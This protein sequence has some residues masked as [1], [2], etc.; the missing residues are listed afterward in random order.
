MVQEAVRSETVF[1]CVLSGRSARAANGGDATI[2]APVEKYA[3]SKTKSIKNPAAGQSGEG[4]GEA[5]CGR[6]QG[7]HKR[8]IR[9]QSSAKARCL[10]N[11]E[12]AQ[13]VPGSS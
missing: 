3:A 10:R 2:S 5:S 12:G 13:A 1:E 11:A 9:E 7:A 8:S 6:K 4:G